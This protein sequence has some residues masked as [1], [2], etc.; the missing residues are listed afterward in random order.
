MTS[1]EILIQSLVGIAD[2]A[3]SPIHVKY[4]HMRGESVEPQ[5]SGADH[6]NIR[7][8]R[9]SAKKKSLIVIRQT[10]AFLQPTIASMFEG[11]D[12]V[13]V[14]VDRRLHDRRRESVS[15]SDERRTRTK[16]RRAS[17][18]ILDVLINIDA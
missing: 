16:D 3:E 10:Y 18:P 17:S 5:G 7:Q 8:D 4:L 11:V 13:Q 15:V 14:I 9:E 1:M 6:M 12:D 2:R